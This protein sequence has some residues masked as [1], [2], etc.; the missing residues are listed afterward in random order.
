MH[1]QSLAGTLWVIARMVFRDFILFS[2]VVAVVLYVLTNRLLL[3][4]S[5]VPHATASD[6]R[7]EL[8]Y[9]FDVAVNSFFPACLTIYIALLPLAS[10]V[11]RNNWV[12][13][14]F[15]K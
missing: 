14:F 6:T 12:C 9:A 11:T 5:A 7:V 15:G 8:A 4:P 13:L 1:R 2:L 3:A 10:V